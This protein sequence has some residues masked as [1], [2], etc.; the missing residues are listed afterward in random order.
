LPSGEILPQE[1]IEINKEN[2]NILRKKTFLFFSF[3]KLFG[4]FKLIIN[5]E[6]F[7][8]NGETQIEF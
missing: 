4:E 3:E 7:N 1:I 5:E 2:K 8:K 6:F